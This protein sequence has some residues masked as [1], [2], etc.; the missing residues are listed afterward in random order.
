MLFLFLSEG[1]YSRAAVQK[2]SIQRRIH[3]WDTKPQRCGKKWYGQMRHPSSFS[4]SGRLHEVYTI[5]TAHPVA[6]LRSGGILM[7]WFGSTCRLCR[8]CHCKSIQ[9]CFARSYLSCDETF[10][11]W[12]EWEARWRLEYEND[13]NHMLWPSRAFQH[14]DVLGW[15]HNN[16]C[17]RF[18]TDVL[19]TTTYST[20]FSL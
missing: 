2:P 4:T 12:W 6:L 13:V 8:K 18:W 9:S 15:L 20:I 10:L 16:T 19:F 3:I 14:N 1:C 11:S 17:G 7:S 5:R